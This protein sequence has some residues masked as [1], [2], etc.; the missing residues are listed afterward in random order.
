[1]TVVITVDNILGK[2]L[3]EMR[4][5][6][7]GGQGK[8]PS[9]TTIIKMVFQENRELKLQVGEQDKRLKELDDLS[10]RLENKNEELGKYLKEL[11]DVNSEFQEE[12]K[13]LLDEVVKL[14]EHVAKEQPRKSFF[15]KI[16]DMLKPNDI[17]KAVLDPPPKV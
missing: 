10:I 5:K 15:T 6:M 17:G 16:W 2:K 12:N 9:H 7:S 8:T 3:N 4:K 1:M 13:E 14:R 11:G